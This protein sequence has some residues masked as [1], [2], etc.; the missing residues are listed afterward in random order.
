[1]HGMNLSPRLQGARNFI[2]WRTLVAQ[3]L[4]VRY[5]GTLLGRAWPLLMPLI[6]L[7]M[8]G[9]VFGVVFRSRWPGLAPDDH[10]G[11]ALNL[12]LGL[13]LHTLLAESVGQSPLLMQSNSNFVRKVVFP[14]PVLVGVPLGSALFHMFLGVLLVCTV[15]AVWG[16]GVHP[17]LLLMP[18]VLLPYLAMLYGL[19]LCFAALGVYIRDLGQLISVLVAMLLFTSTVLFSR[20]AVPAKLAVVVDVNPISWP[21]NSLREVVLLGQVPALHGTLI[22]TAVATLVLLVGAWVFKTL[23]PGFADV[24]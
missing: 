24:L 11:Y 17:T 4:A 14:L 22:Y 8:Y 18:L 1:M 12:F 6:M 20:S 23:R 9:F 7:A 10:L 19:S 5:R 16:P 2:L 13:L 15:A 3:D 21:V